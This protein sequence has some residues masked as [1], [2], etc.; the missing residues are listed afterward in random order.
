VAYYIIESGKIPDVVFASNDPYTI[1]AIQ[2]FKKNGFRITEDIAFIS[3]TESHMETIIKPPLSSVL[4]P[5]REIGRE[6]ATV[7]LE[8]IENLTTYNPQVIVL[9]GQLNIRESSTKL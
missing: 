7:L 1:G 5:A 9:N 4:Q 3:F 6:A 8:Q 2:V